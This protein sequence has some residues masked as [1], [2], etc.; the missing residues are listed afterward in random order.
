[1]TVI[2][3]AASPEHGELRHALAQT[4]IAAGKIVGIAW[5]ELCG[6]I[7]FR[8]AFRR[9]I[10]PQPANAPGPFIALRQDSVEMARVRAIDH[11]VSRTRI[12]GSV[13]MMR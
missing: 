10:G 8:M 2:G 11:V 7:E 9:R 6:F 12:R 1:M 5:I 13:D 3:A 4:S